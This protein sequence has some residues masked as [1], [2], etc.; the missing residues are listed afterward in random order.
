MDHG[1]NYESEAIEKYIEYIKE[2]E[3]INIEVKKLG[4]VVYSDFTEFGA[5]P[6]GL[7]F[8]TG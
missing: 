6:D 1:K 4:L 5:S 2:E 7:A 3:D 8:T